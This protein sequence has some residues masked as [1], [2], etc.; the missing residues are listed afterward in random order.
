MPYIEREKC[1]EDEAMHS[2]E[3]GLTGARHVSSALNV[4][5]LEGSSKKSSCFSGPKRVVS[6]TP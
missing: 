6:Q 4:L 1:A 5:R 2:S 3:M